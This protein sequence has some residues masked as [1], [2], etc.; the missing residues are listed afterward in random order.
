MLLI[1]LIK[2]ATLVYRK[3]PMLR[4]LKLYYNMK[5]LFIFSLIYVITNSFN[6]VNAQAVPGLS[7]KRLIVEIGFSGLNHFSTFETYNYK[8][9]KTSIFNKRRISTTEGLYNFSFD[10]Q[11]QAQYA[12]SRFKMLGVNITCARMGIYTSRDEDNFNVSS[13]NI[14]FFRRKYLPMT[15]SIAPI[16][17]YYQYGV[18][19][20]IHRSFRKEIYDGTN[21]PLSYDF[22]T[23]ISPAFTQEF[24]IESVI[25]EQFLYS[26]GM[27][28]T[29]ILPVGFGKM[30]LEDI[31]SSGYSTPHGRLMQHFALRFYFRVGLPFDVN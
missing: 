30:D 17:T 9:T 18:S 3:R 8:D 15:G 19:G 31:L 16:G 24:G 4:T 20:M 21:E 23:S 11:I 7:G 5:K 2:N 26:A 1:C 14:N 12:I 27:Q 6:D 25:G 10:S 28:S 13:A 29:L 22:K